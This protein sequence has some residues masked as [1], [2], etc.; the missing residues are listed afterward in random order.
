[1]VRGTLVVVGGPTAS[2]KTA[3]AAALAARL[4]T[5]VISA[6]A[7]QFYGAMR[8]GTARPTADELL[9]VPHHFLG[10]L[11]LEETWSAGR[12]ARAAEPVLQRLLTEQG[13]AVLVGGSGLYLDA[14]IKGFDPLPEADE[15]LRSRLRERV[16]REGLRSLVDDLARLDP[17]T[18][19]RID[20]RNPQRVL[21]ALEVCLL[22]GRPFSEQRHA[23]QHRTDMD[24]VRVAL[25]PTRP[26]L[27]ARIDARVDA[28]MAAGLLDEARSLLPHRHLTALNTVGYKE[29]F[30]HLDGTLTLARAVDRIKQHT[31]NYA[32]RQLTWLR[33]DPGWVLV[34]AT[35]TAD[36]VEQVLRL[37]P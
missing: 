7:R 31:R 26:V 5:E 4:G 15:A 35:D 27:Y 32:K 2:G 24:I 21:R 1:M 36:G 3:L 12:F 33:R 20:A 34:E 37:L 30:Q 11:D 14:V 19:E 10:H 28:M 6:D 16:Q 18:A 9:G 22:T 23:P 29:L 17:A 13:R 8:I 25:H